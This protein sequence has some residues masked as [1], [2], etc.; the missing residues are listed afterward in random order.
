[1]VVTNGAT[2]LTNGSSLPWASVTGS[3]TSLA[4]YGITNAILTNGSGATNLTG[5]SVLATNTAF[6]GLTAL[7]ATLSGHGITNAVTNG[8]SITNLTGYGT[9]ALSN[10][11][12]FDV[13]GA[14]ASLLNNLNTWT[15]NQTFNGANNIAPNQT[16]AGASSLMT[17]GLSDTRYGPF[18]RLITTAD[19]TS[20]STTYTNG[21]DVLTLPSG[22]Y[23][24]VAL[25]NADTA[26][27]TGGINALLVL[28]ANN[29][30]AGFFFTKY[31]NY[32]SQAV[33]GQGA[34]PVVSFR[35]Q[36]SAAIFQFAVNALQDNTAG[37][38]IMAEFSGWVTFNASTTLNFKVAQRNASDAS[39]PAILRKNSYIQF[40]KIQ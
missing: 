40:Q 25:V 6:A 17:M 3:P 23:Q 29:D 1:M 32:A 11:T 10:S 30:T 2:V 19:I 33:T 38:S 16:A 7:P 22:T 12:A 18:Y 20:A 8:A 26:S 34:S 35:N 28:S 15:N 31:C 9:A 13:N 37:K 5:L 4:G 21:S 27:S 39:N 36:N 24:Y 14:A